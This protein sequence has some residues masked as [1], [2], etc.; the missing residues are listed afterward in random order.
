MILYLHFQESEAEN[1]TEPNKNRK[2]KAP[3]TRKKGSKRKNTNK[4]TLQVY[5]SC[6]V[7]DNVSKSRN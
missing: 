4:L 5:S 6:T 2:W 3:V 7:L 1:E